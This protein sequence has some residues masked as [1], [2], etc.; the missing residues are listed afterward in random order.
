MNECVNGAV[1]RQR[2]R[3][4]VGDRRAVVGVVG[5]ESVLFEHAP[6]ASDAD[7][8]AAK[9]SERVHNRYMKLPRLE[10][11]TD[12][13]TES[14]LLLRLQVVVEDA[15]PLRIVVEDQPERHVEHGHEEPDLDAGRR[16]EGAALADGHELRR[17]RVRDRRAEAPRW[18]R[19]GSA[20]AGIDRLHDV[21]LPREPLAGARTWPASKNRIARTGPAIVM[22]CSTLKSRLLLPPS[23]RPVTGSDGPMLRMS[24]PRTVYSPP[25]NSFSKIGSGSEPSNWWMYSTWRANAERHARVL[26]PEIH[27]LERRLVEADV[28]AK[29]G[30]IERRVKRRPDVGKIGLSTVLWTML[31]VIL[32]MMRS[33]PWP[34]SSESCRNG[35]RR[36][37]V[38]SV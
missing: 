15:R 5:E 7:G 20:P 23:T 28:A 13:E 4:R 16:L 25:R 30:Q 19:P 26:L 37:T 21:F 38:G 33:P 3:E 9:R 36:R 2:A 35:F 34:M 24:K 18:D 27:A 10:G 14:E 31:G 8:R 11:R 22:A 29:P 1:L 12:G 17:R 6:V 32:L